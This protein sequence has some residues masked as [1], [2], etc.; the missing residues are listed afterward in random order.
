MA[1]LTI[2]EGAVYRQAD[3]GEWERLSDA[4]GRRQLI[5]QQ[6]VQNQSAMQR[7]LVGA[8][9]YFRN[10]LSGARELLGLG[11]PM[12]EQQL[13]A[14]TQQE[15]QPH[16]EYGGLPVQ[17]G[18]FLAPA[19]TAVIPGGL[20][21]QMGI[22]AAQGAAENPESPFAGAGMGAAFTWA[23]DWLAQG[24]GRLTRTLTAHRQSLDP[25]IRSQ[26]EAGEALGLEFTPGQREGALSSTRR[27]EK[28]L[29]KNPR[30]A[31]LDEQR[32]LNNQAALNNAAAEA[33]GETPTG[34]VTA[35][36]RGNVA[37]KVGQA[38]DDVAK[39]SEPVQ[40][41]GRD[42]LD[43]V[44][45]LTDAGSELHERFIRKFPSLFE[46]GPISGKQ[47][48]DARNWL[49]KQTRATANIQS[50]AAEEMQPFLRVMDDSLEA[51]NIQANPG[52]V[53][54]IRDARQRW[55]ALLVIEQAQRGAESAAQGNV[56]ALSAYNALRKYDKGGIF[57][58][59]GRD[60]FATI[61][62][63]MAAAG[64]TVA[65]QPPSQDV[66]G[67]VLRGVDQLLYSGPAAE[68]YMRGENI[69]RV[70]LGQFDE[71]QPGSVEGLRALGIGTGRGLMADENELD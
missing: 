9:G 15:L 8:G 17:A 47:F 52:L 71:L 16:Q 44:G 46:G 2:H 24:L 59:Q 40:L 43:Q 64:D 39:N 67:G 13:R 62:D 10:T 58:G 42:W 3:G 34:Y 29:A 22:G 38:F 63:A 14:E 18:E 5:M 31:A 1:Q 20:K 61:V 35:Q 70:M 65:P 54:R 50:G 21:A 28:Q 49:A 48:I 37:N 12:A 11:D 33:L 6:G 26:I 68:R 32:F 25:G 36:M 66:A 55:K 69:G 19:A 41:I 56:P 4:E 23:G 27:M 45:D 60:N 7:G 53:G 51:A 30:F 57:R